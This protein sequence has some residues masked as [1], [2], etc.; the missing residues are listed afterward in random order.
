MKILI[1]VGVAAGLVTAIAFW[2]RKAQAAG[3]SL[4]SLAT[5]RNFLIGV[6][7]NE[8][9]LDAD[10]LYSKVAAREFNV[11]TTMNAL[12]FVNTERERNIF[13]FEGG[14]KI[15][16]FARNN[17]MKVRGHTLI[18][19]ETA[20]FWL[21]NGTWTRDELISILQTHVS[22]VVRYYKGLVYA[23]DVVNEA[24]NKNT[25]QLNE[26]NF[27]YKTI[28]PE[29]IDL[30]FLAAR[31]ADP[32][33]KL[34]YN[35][36]R[37]E[38]IDD[39]KADAIYNLVKGMKERNISIDGVGMQMHVNTMEYRD[40]EKVKANMDRLAQL[41]LEIQITEMTVIMPAPPT[42][43]N[44]ELQAN[45]YGDIL[46]V[47]LSQPACTAFVM[48]MLTD[49]YVDKSPEYGYSTIFDE[50]YQ[51]KPAYYSLQRALG[52]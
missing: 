23:W 9:K 47:C 8:N 2:R 43:E 36:F 44:L 45:I 34:F 46:K 1:G 7:I 5:A 19:N 13:T 27:W 49:K 25:G 15:V 11:V 28:G 30:A 18:K 52:G 17:K 6:S 51:P 21:T 32:Q 12:K 42:P 14:N 50:N 10:P 26:N 16:R 3:K 24:V 20:P 35:D 48:W 22:T 41:G 29:Y 38:A 39:E 37:G 4:R 40:P 33:A 31:K